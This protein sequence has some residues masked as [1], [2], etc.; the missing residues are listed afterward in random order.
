MER[1]DGRTSGA[2]GV[3]ETMSG[4]GAA[5]VGAGTLILVLFP[6][7]IPFLAL[8]AVFVAPLLLLLGLVAA[9]PALVVAGAVLA[10]RRVRARPPVV[11]SGDGVAGRA[12]AASLGS[13]APPAPAGA[14]SHPWL[15]P[16]GRP[17]A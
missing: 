1:T 9:I 16:G 17:T 6:L 3:A 11:P 12:R 7:S 8:T 10:I 13:S 2:N 5:A 14:R 15:W 4:I